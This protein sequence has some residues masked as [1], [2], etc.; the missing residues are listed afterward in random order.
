MAFVDSWVETDPDGAVITGSLL[1]DYDRQTKRAVRER[2]EGDPTNLNSGIFETGTFAATA[3]VRAGTARAYA[4][5]AASVAGLTVQDGRIA[6]TTDTKRLFHLKATGAVELDYMPNGG[7]SALTPEYGQVGIGTAPVVSYKLTIRESVAQPYSALFYNRNANQAWGLIVDVASVDD[8]KF[9]IVDISSLATRLS[10]D[11]AGLVTVVGLAASTVAATSISGTLT[12]AAQANITSLGTL[13]SL[14]VSGLVTAS[15]GVLIDGGS[16]ASGKIYKSASAGLG[17]P[18]IT[19]SS[20]DIT[21]LTPGGTSIVGVPTGTVNVSLAGHILADTDNIKDIGASGATRFRTGYFGTSV[22]APLVSSA[23]HSLTGSSSFT[24][25][26]DIRSSSNILI[27]NG[28]TGGYSLNSANDGVAL[29]TLTNAGVATFASSVIAK[30]TLQLLASS[31]NVA[32]F[33]TYD[34]TGTYN[35]TVIRADQ[36]GTNIA[37]MVFYTS[38]SGI[39]AKWRI[40]AAGHLLAE[41]DNAFDI[42]AVGAT[43][44]RNVYIGSI[45]VVGGGATIN[46]TAG[47]TLYVN[48]SDTSFGTYLT[49]QIATVDKFYIGSWTNVIGAGSTGDLAIRSATAA[50]RIGFAIGTTAIAT[51]TSTGILFPTDNTYDIGGAGTSRPRNLNVGTNATIAGLI[52]VGGTSTDLSTRHAFL[53]ANGLAVQYA[54]STGTY[55]NIIPGPANSVVSLVAD[56][57][58]GAYPDIRINTSA[59]DRWSFTASGHLVAVSDNAYDLGATGANRPR[60]FFLARNFTIG[61]WIAQSAS[62]NGALVDMTNTDTTNG[63]GLAIRANGSAATR[64]VLRATNAAGS[65]VYFTV[66]TETGKVGYVGVGTDTPTE[67]LHVVGNGTFTGA[68]YSGSARNLKRNVEDFVDN[69]CDLLEGIKVVNYEYNLDDP[70]IRRVGFIAE[71]TNS[72]FSGVGRNRFDY[73]NTIAVLIAANQEL[74]RRVRELEAR[75]N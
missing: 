59:N 75:L 23:H 44:P 56:A 33:N 69:A 21:L 22:V 19:G 66:Q 11:S 63:Y 48:S 39:G 17:I 12:T 61:G 54:G 58:S 37:D 53:G 16:F 32:D 15:G 43:R 45:L 72:L 6:I 7:G 34:S 24:Q 27:F 62:V 41:T 68:V 31:G 51:V 29:L 10:I 25:A 42:G 49:I 35:L 2:L 14:A 57:R 1:D 46:K 5:T 50:S 71:E 4:V 67:K 55:F 47:D 73:M 52:L 13:T 64:Y 65:T 26:L 9:G 38:N 60:D 74:N 8:K 70:G 40:K 30:N 36:G 20:N 28:G 18:G 3:I